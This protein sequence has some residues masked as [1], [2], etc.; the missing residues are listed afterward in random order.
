MRIDNEIHNK[1]RYRKLWKR[2]RAEGRECGICHQPIDYSLPADHPF[3]FEL[4]H[5]D[6]R[7]LGGAIYDYDNCQAAH[8]ICNQR[9]GKKKQSEVE[10][11]KVKKQIGKVQTC[12]EW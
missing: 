10:T 9:K 1:T 11:G 6:P 5:I 4:D 12:S 8:R 3:C 7:G 2:V